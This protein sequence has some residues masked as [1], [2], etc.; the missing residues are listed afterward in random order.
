MAVCSMESVVCS[1]EST[2]YSAQSTLHTRFHTTY[3]SAQSNAYCT[4]ALGDTTYSYGGYDT[5]GT[6]RLQ[7]QKRSHVFRKSREI[8][9]S[10]LRVALCVHMC[11]CVCAC[12]RVISLCLFPSLPLS[13][14]LLSARRGSSK[15]NPGIQLVW[16]SHVLN[17]LPIC[18]PP[19][20]PILNGQFYIRAYSC[21][22]S[23]TFCIQEHN[24]QGCIMFPAHVIF[25][26]LDYHHH[27]TRWACIFSFR[28]MLIDILHTQSISRNTCR[29]LPRN[30]NHATST[31]AICESA[32]HIGKKQSILLLFLISSYHIWSR[33]TIF[34]KDSA[35]CYHMKS[36]QHYD[37][38]ALE[39]NFPNKIQLLCSVCVLYLSFSLFLSH[40]LS[41]FVCGCVCA[42]LAPVCVC[43]C[44]LCSV[45]VSVWV[46]RICW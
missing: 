28:P 4:M 34:G 35:H 11:V 12:I 5:G 20:W 2:Y 36:P 44:L 21:G 37:Y 17:M 15:L 45:S 18:Y 10:P 16:A 22:L 40:T 7:V 25:K 29:K 13:L 38:L 6:S 46:W 41:L 43:L 39:F 1:M 9:L 19:M 26:W 31:I 32:I 8:G 33:I 3:Y 24:H 30:P 27:M 23:I 42:W 14:S